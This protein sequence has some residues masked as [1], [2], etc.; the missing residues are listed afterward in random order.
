MYVRQ[1]ALLGGAGVGVPR[2]ADL[3]RARAAGRRG[4]AARVRPAPPRRRALPG[5]PQAAQCA[6]DALTPIVRFST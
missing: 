6:G 2:A 5:A 4:H 3:Q 1:A